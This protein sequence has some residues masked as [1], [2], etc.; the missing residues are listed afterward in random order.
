M[1]TPPTRPPPPEPAQRRLPQRRPPAGGGL[2]A[3]RPQGQAAPAEAQVQ[4]ETAAPSALGQTTASG[5]STAQMQVA[6]AGIAV[7]AAQGAVLGERVG[8]G[9]TTGETRTLGRAQGK[10]QTLYQGAAAGQTTATGQVAATG[11]GVGR[12]DRAPVSEPEPEPENRVV[13]PTKPVPSRHTVSLL[14][15]RAGQVVSWELAVIAVALVYRERLSILIPVAVAAVLLVALTTIRRHE[16]WLYQWLGRWL[17]FRS[18]RRRQ[19]MPTPEAGS[20]DEVATTLLAAVVR[21]ADIVPVEIDEVQVALISHAGGLTAVLDVTAPDAGHVVEPSQILPPLPGLLPSAE[22]GEPVITAQIIIQSIPAPNFLG[23]ADS[24]AISY[25]ELAGGVVPATRGCWLAMQAQH[26]AEEYTATELQESL[27]RAVRRVQRRLRKAG[28]RARLLNRDEIATELLNLARVDLGHST[29]SGNSP[30]K[31]LDTPAVQE[32][33]RC[34]SAGPQVHTTFRLLDWPDLADAEGRELLDRLVHTP[35][36]ATTV[37]VA[38]RRSLPSE[39]LEL[40]AA[41]RVTLPDG[42]A[43]AAATNHIREIVSAVGGRV[44]RADGEHVF[45]VAATLPLGGFLS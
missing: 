15:I 17:R 31:K 3:T 14:G 13:I 24:A 20:S 4:G 21:G 23:L 36:L 28:L 41:I 11:E 18:R 30:A 12:R 40:E 44:E 9:Q 16:H 25:R 29:S 19:K 7:P 38:A 43:V 27:I 1:T 39:D 8:I 26:V 35:T 6:G 34:W 2:A 42:Q 32:S 37:T 33:W 22:V 10:G 5:R 45:G